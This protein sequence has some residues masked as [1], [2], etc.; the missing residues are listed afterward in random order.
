MHD[1]DTLLQQQEN[2]DFVI[3]LKTASSIGAIAFLFFSVLDL[4]V[5]P[6]LASQF[7]VYRIIIAAYLGGTALVSGKL[8]K[9]RIQFLLGLLA[10][11]ASAATLEAMILRTGGHASSYATGMILLVVCVLAYAQGGMLFPA[12]AALAIYGIYV[13]PIVATEQIT[14]FRSFIASNFFLLS[15][16]L[17]MLALRHL[18]HRRVRKQNSERVRAERSLRE[19]EEKF[20]TL[21]ES[22]NDAIFMLSLEGRFLD[23]NRIGYERLGYAKEEILAK[24]VFE[25]VPPGFSEKVSGRLSQISKQGHSVFES[26]HVRKD[27]TMLP[28]E[29]NV[30]VAEYGGNQGLLSIARDI[31]ERR[32][33]QTRLEQQSAEQNA[34]LEN[35]L[36][37][38]AHLRDRKFIWIN[39]K[40]EQMFGYERGKVTGLTTELFYPSRE[41]YEAFGHEAY[42]LLTSGDTYHAERLMKRID[43]S[44]FWCSLSGKAIDHTVPGEGS[45]WILQDISQRKSAEEEIRRINQNLE[46]LVSERARELKQTNERLVAEIRER[47]WFEEELIKAQKLE[48]LGILAG[49]LAHDFNNML[50]AILGNLTLAMLDLDRT[51]TVFRSLETAET[52]ALRAQDLTKQLLTFARGGA[53]VKRTVA[54]GELVRDSVAFAL[55]GSRVK[56]DISLQD[57]LWPVEADEG[58]LVQVMHNL[59]I[60][61]DH[62]MPQGG[63]ISARCENCVLNDNEAPSVAR[64]KYVRIIVRDRGMGIPEDH[65][66]KI[67]DPYFTTKQK[68]SGLGLAT[69]YSV[70]QKHGGRIFAESTLGAGA[71]FTILLP[72]SDA[73][74]ASGK[75]VENIIPTGEG[76]ILVMDDEA[77]IRLTACDV[78]ERLGYRA[79]HAA[80]GE[81]AIKLYRE[82]FHAGDP[83]QAVIMDLTI[84]GGMGGAETLQLLREL[85]PRVKGIVSSGYSNDPVM[86][87]YKKYGFAD[88]VA[89]P[90]RVRELGEAVFRVILGT[91]DEM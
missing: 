16:I 5:F 31:T 32:N 57:G 81:S 27:G 54:I 1:H 61:A 21:F 15:I 30:R 68:G 23:I 80:D 38:I 76:K 82:A 85:D 25:I 12:L 87:E 17:A 47:K 78:L 56:H 83:F 26:V 53:P 45:I 7:F 9:P 18:T 52:A 41:S 43:G 29:I 58:Q 44:L 6:G 51:A 33:M 42:P 34:I 10:V 48:S 66:L 65:L 67:F 89:K 77:D 70:I 8:A 62:A 64:G 14:D 13:L 50:T 75:P 24:Y 55:R 73:V 72:A 4:I 28:V 88:V 35:A 79:M 91:D 71:T 3:W 19:S 2:E 90:Y 63:T 74:M 36:V 46:I 39:G 20:H 11:I 40:M 69:A 86:A 60:N 22:A 84:P 49:G 37:G 59:V